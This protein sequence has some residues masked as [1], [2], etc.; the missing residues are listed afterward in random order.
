MF[1][2]IRIEHSDGNG[3][4]RSA[5]NK[6]RRYELDNSEFTRQMHYLHRGIPA[7]IYMH[8]F[9]KQHYCAF[10]SMETFKPF[11]VD[12][13]LKW[14]LNNGFKVLLIDVKSV[15]SDGYQVA[16][17]K[18]DIISTKDISSLFL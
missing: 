15:I 9:T 11:I 14:L 8:G 5:D 6:C 16:Y 13:E 2:V 10:E 17:K 7:A 12:N 1:T 3:I 18:C 4:W